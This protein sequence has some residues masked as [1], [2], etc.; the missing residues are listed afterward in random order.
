MSIYVNDMGDIISFTGNMDVGA[1][2]IAHRYLHAIAYKH[3]TDT[4]YWDEI[5]PIN[6]KDPFEEICMLS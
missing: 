6:D 3:K 2:I 4:K 5:V 1:E